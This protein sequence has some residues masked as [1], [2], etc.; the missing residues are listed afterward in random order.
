MLCCSNFGT[1]LK[2]Q[3]ISRWEKFQGVRV[4]GAQG[5]DGAR[6]LLRKNTTLGFD[7]WAAGWQSC[8]FLMVC[9]RLPTW[10]FVGVSK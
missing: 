10:A 9:V 7:A 6:G 8:D 3:Y 1:L 2:M 4:T 5:P